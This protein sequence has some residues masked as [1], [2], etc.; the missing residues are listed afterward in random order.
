MG[1]AIVISEKRYESL[2]M[3]PSSQEIPGPRPPVTD[4]FG[5]PVRSLRIS[6]TQVCDLKCP[7]CHRE[8]QTES[9][10]EMTPAELERL[11][12]ISRAIGVRKVKLTGGEPLLRDDIVDVVSRISPLVSE[13]SMTTNGT[14]LSELSGQL[15]R[16]G[17]SRVNVSLHSLDPGVYSRLCGRDMVD[18]VVSGIRSALDAGLTPVKV[19]MVVMRGQNEHEIQA[20]IRFCSEVG[21]VLQLIEYE[22]DRESENGCH[23]AQR[24]Y[25]L[26]GVEDELAS[27]ASEVSANEL[28]RR[29]RYLIERRGKPVLVEVVRP[30]HNSEFCSNCTRLRLSSDGKLKPCLLDRSG[31]TDII[32]PLRGGA[33]DAEIRELFIRTISNRRPYWG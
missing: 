19:N 24:F 14:R 11:V 15:R 13:V 17:L 18:K 12:G 23:F 30:M 2:S 9:A 31:D 8:G 5:R 20:M 21:A 22:T 32:T 33:S 28:H 3:S 10:S 29:R 6:V 1:R 7:H 27:L 16:A 25:S 26:K 4:P